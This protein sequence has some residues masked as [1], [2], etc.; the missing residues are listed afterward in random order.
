M[1]LLW[2]FLAGTVLAFSYAAAVCEGGRPVSA[3]I[4]PDLPQ[5]DRVSALVLTW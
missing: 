5:N 4:T 1:T 2:Y 3:R